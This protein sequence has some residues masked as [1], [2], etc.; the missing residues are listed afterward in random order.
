[1]INAY[2]CNFREILRAETGHKYIETSTGAAT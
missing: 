1:M 2:V